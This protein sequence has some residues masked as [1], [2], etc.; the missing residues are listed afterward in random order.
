MLGAITWRNATLLRFTNRRSGSLRN[1]AENTANSTEGKV[2]EFHPRYAEA[3]GA[4]LRQPG[5]AY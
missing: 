5:R 1:S 3:E 2:R 4:L